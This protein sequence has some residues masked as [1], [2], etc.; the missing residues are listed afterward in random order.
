LIARFQ[1]VHNTTL[2]T[3]SSKQTSPICAGTGAAD[4]AVVI[5]ICAGT[6]AVDAGV[7]PIY[8]G[9]GAADA[10]VCVSVAGNSAV[11]LFYIFTK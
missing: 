5:P 11:Q 10:G 7:I 6:G 3:H 1:L 2:L 9:T 8:A 4:D